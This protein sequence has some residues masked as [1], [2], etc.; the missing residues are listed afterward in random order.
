[1]SIPK[2]LFNLLVLCVLGASTLLGQSVPDWTD[3]V[4]RA[5][6]YPSDRY[7]VGYAL[8]SINGDETPEQATDRII[9]SAQNNMLENIRVYMTSATESF[10]LSENNDG[11]YYENEQFENHTVKNA[12]ADIVG[13]KIDSYFD[14]KSKIVYAL[15]YAKREEVAAYHKKILQA[16]LSQ[17]EGLLSTAETMLS[18]ND[19][20]SARTQCSIALPIFDQIKESQNLLIAI[21][22]KITENDLQQEWTNRLY[23]SLSKLLS[24]LDPKFEIIDN[25]KNELTQKLL[26][27][28]SCLSTCDELLSV[29]E[30]NNARKL[31]ESA[32]NMMNTIRSVQDSMRKI[33]PS[34]SVQTLELQRTEKL[35]NNIELLSSQLSQAIVIYIESSEEL[36][37]KQVTIISDKLRAKLSD[38]GC[39]FTDDISKADFKLTI[40]SETKESS[41]MEN[42]VFCYA[43]VTFDLFDTHKQRLVYRDDISEK[44]GSTTKEKAA[45]KAA[46]S[47]ADTIVRKIVKWIK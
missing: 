21:N 47:S 8:G 44:G 10:I 23:Q 3:D 6:L 11:Q 1:M 39:S 42:L 46:E 25:L 31:C 13:M 9:N 33:D 4:I 36:F 16:N 19:K 28:E 2:I 45:S 22:S 26:Q 27:V 43:D 5:V 29:G 18:Q 17:V 35:R 32:K 40:S 34:V 20:E 30:K 24:Q 14:K 7:F 38:D 37:G 15:S 12:V 41:R